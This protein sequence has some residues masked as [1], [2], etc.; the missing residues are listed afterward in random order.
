MICHLKNHN[1]KNEVQTTVQ[2]FFPN[3][4]CT[5]CAQ[6][7][8]VGYFV[9]TEI[10]DPVAICRVFEDGV[11]VN[12]TSIS[13]KLREIEVLQLP[14]RRVLMLAI[15]HALQK[16]VGAYTPWGALTGIRPSKM[17]R[18]WI[19]QG[20]TKDQVI[21]TMGNPFCCSPHKAT[22]AHTVAMAEKNLT[23]KIYAQ[24]KNPI[25]I[26]I[27][28][29]FCPT[30]C[31]YCSFSVDHNFASKNIHQE[32]IDALVKE[33]ATKAA[34]LKEICGNVSSVYIGGGTP[35]ALAEPLLQ[36]LLEAVAINFD[37]NL[38]YTVE[39]GRPDTLTTNKLKLL[40]SY[41]VNRIA[42]NPQT[43]KDDTLAFIG[44][45]HTA[46]QF[47][48]AF[49]NARDA[50]FKT[51]NTDVIVGLPGETLEDVAHTMERLASLAPENITVHTLAIK[52]ASTLNQHL[53]KYPLPTAHQTEAMLATAQE[54]CQGAGLN[55]YYM[56]RQKNMVGMFENL[57]Y[58]KAGH[59]CLYNVGMMAETQTVLGIG[60]GAVSKFVEDG[61]IT[62]EFN[63][64]NPEIYVQRQ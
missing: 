52:R 15:Y 4:G 22:L 13:R 17:V 39:A 27:S 33:C 63:V 19:D 20:F 38:E 55:P 37:T 5:F 59:E 6:M 51:I 2:L 30:R 3:T 47:Y 8:P 64:K 60:A 26:Y 9:E 56:Y 32:Y 14:M 25:G 23:E 31:V 11:L 16:V 50:G 18:E 35:T 43:L 36:Q 61:L 54:I 28:V 46:D 10:T 44:R 57:G 1:Y 21:A 45:K 29:P 49:E 58:S 48:R 53:D 40:A 7:P 42:V 12:E 41:G 34:Y 24:V 62:R